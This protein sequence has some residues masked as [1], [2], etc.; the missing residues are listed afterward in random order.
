MKVEGLSSSQAAASRRAN[1]L[2]APGF[3][4]PMGETQQ[5]QATRAAT[6]PATITNVGSLLALQGVETID[7]R[8][9]RATR[10]ANILLDQLEDI[11]IAT[12]SG[13]VSRNQLANLSQT[14]RERL[15][16][17]ED[18]A[19]SAILEEVELRAEVELAKLERSL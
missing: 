18:P 14:L 6:A 7:E 10:R 5:A 11:K 17:V 13:N 4:V 12:L 19:L 2:A 1:G 3:N 15:D 16:D 9:R 8:R